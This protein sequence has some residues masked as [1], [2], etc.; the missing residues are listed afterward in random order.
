M[1]KT[2]SLTMVFLLIAGF[3]SVGFAD[4]TNGLRGEPD[5][6]YFRYYEN[7][8]ELVGK[9]DTVVDTTTSWKIE[10]SASTMTELNSKISATLSVL[11]I[12][13]SDSV[14]TATQIEEGFKV[15]ISCSK[16]MHIRVHR[17]V[18]NTYRYHLE[19]RTNTITGETVVITLSKTYLSSRFEDIPY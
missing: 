7:R 6:S 8:E 13:V 12:G 2:I 19:R 9:H 10:L 15:I 11:D 5:V 16:V 4:A 17:S 3:L 18:Y 1:R 14:G